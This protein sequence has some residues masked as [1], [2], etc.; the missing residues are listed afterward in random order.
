MVS[1]NLNLA[2]EFADD[3]VFLKNGE[4][5]AHGK[6]D[7]VFNE[8]ILSK[9]FDMQ[10]NTITNPFTKRLNIVYGGGIEN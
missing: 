3:M 6:V 9:I 2:A 8:T 5:I 10:I 7:Q 1:H 4:I